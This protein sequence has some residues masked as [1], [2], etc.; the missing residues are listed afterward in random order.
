MR[1]RVR[2]YGGRLAAGAEGDDFV[3]RASLPVDAAP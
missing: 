1:E 3:I 2:V